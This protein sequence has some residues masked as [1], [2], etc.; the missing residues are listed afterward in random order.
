[1]LGNF[2][3][4]GTVVVDDVAVGAHVGEQRFH[5]R[6]GQVDAIARLHIAALGVAG[7]GILEHLGTVEE[8][9][10]LLLAHFDKGLVVLVHLGLGQAL[11]GVLLPQR[12]DG[13]DDNIHTGVGFDNALDA[14][15]VIFDKVS[16]LIAGAQIV[17]AKRDDDPFGLHAR[18]GFGHRNISAGVVQLHTGVGRQA[19]G[20]HAHRAN[21]VVIG[22]VV[23]HAVHAGGVAVAQKERFVHIGLPGIAAFGQDGGRKCGCV[24]GVF[25]FIVA[26]LRNDGL[27]LY[28]RIRSGIPTAKAAHQQKGDAY[29]D[30]QHQ[31]ANAQHNVHFGPEIQPHF[32]F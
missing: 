10:A 12:R 16:R 20:A 22:A 19:F 27:G 11:V 29:A 17:G 7:G 15:L 5:R 4:R 6:A 8:L 28:G 13:V 31:A 14:G 24:D 21:G 26:A 1:M 9:P 2:R 18:H 30:Q 25:L 3:D 32:R 23:K